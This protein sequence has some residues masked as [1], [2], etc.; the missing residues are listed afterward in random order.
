MQ[1][2]HRNRS[3]NARG[4]WEERVLSP[5]CLIYATHTLLYE[6]QTA[7]KNVDD[8]HNF[9][10]LCDILDTPRLPDCIF[11]PSSTT[12]DSALSGDDEIVKAGTKF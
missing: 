7:H 3:T 11:L 10:K 5:R 4:A 2:G 6:C 12:P 9:V 1:T 8:G